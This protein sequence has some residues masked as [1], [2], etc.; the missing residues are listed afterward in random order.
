MSPQSGIRAAMF[1]PASPLL[2]P[3]PPVPQPPVPT[4]QPYV[5]P[6]P[7]FDSEGSLTRVDAPD[8]TLLAIARGELPRRRGPSIGWFIFGVLAG[9][10]AVWVAT[11]GAPA[12]VYRARLW[13]ADSLRALHGRLSGTPVATPANNATARPAPSAAPPTNIPVVNVADLPRSPDPAASSA[14]PPSVPLATPPGPR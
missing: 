7:A 8:S 6:R 4:P 10:V 14:P 1:P 13:V 2:L 11:G 5:P 12:D 9:A 3:P